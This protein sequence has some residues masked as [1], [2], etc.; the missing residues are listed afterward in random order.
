MQSV[1]FCRRN[2]IVVAIHRLSVGRQS[3][4]ICSKGRLPFNYCSG[5][6]E[7]VLRIETAALAAL[8]V[9]VAGLQDTRAPAPFGE[10]V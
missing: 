1:L 3:N 7:G 4:G 2:F 10:P 9:C 6:R 8:A 5:N